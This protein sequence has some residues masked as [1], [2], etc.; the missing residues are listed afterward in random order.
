MELKIHHIGYLVKKIEASIAEFQQLGFIEKSKSFDEIRK[1][2]ICFME[3]DGYCVELIAPVKDSELY[4]LMKKCRNMAYHFCYNVADAQLAISE[5]EEKGYHL[6]K[7][8]EMAPAIDQDAQVA[9]LMNPEVGMIELL[10]HGNISIVVEF[11]RKL[12]EKSVLQSKYITEWQDKYT[13]NELNEFSHLIRFFVEKERKSMSDIVDAYL[14]LNDM[15]AEEQYFFAVNGHYRFSKLAEVE[16]AVY[17]NSTY[18][19]KY[20]MGL[21]VSDYIWIQHIKMV[22]FFEKF[23]DFS[24]GGARYLEVG[25]GYGQYMRHAIC[26]NKYENYQACDLSAESV[27]GCKLFLEYALPAKLRNKWDVTQQ[28]LFDLATEDK[29]DMIVMGEVLEHV[30]QPMRMLR[31]IQEHLSETGIAFV[32]TVI[33]AP[34]VDHIYLFHTVDEVKQ[35]VRDAGFEIIEYEVFTA[36]DIAL[37]K[38]E[39]KKRPIDIAMVI[40]RKV[41]NK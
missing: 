27:R 6:I 3:K 35:L 9:F 29:Y 10:Q 38:A 21:A 2:Y 28:N 25:P 11:F 8:L 17:G 13:S 18:M 37:E 7:E 36:G 41:E 22:R 31:K 30:E 15:I 4:G 32:S 39:K 1:S 14:F 40:K 20:M 33:N 24:E 12:K 26:S 19:E 23:L 16:D 5:L 34:A